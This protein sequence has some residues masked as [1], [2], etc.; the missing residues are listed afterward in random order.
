LINIVMGGLEFFCLGPAVTGVPVGQLSESILEGEL[1]QVE[2]SY[3]R[4][5]G[6]IAG[7]GERSQ[8]EASDRRSKAGPNSGPKRCADVLLAGDSKHRE[9]I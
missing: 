4:W 1:S 7:G 9:D 6:A 8:V 2:G 3:R 5:R